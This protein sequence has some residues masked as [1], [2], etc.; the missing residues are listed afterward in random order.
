MYMDG[1]GVTQDPAEALKW[2]ESA[3]AQGLLDAQFALGNIFAGGSGM[4]KD[5]VRAYMWYDITA[6]HSG[7]DWLRH[8]AASN[9]DAV[10]ARMNPDEVS[11]ARGLAEDWRTRH[12]M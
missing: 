6:S 9:R 8:I 1:Q 7:D 12:G 10:A 3:A 2:L 5:N 11:E 4:P